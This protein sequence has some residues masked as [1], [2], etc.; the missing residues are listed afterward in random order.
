MN[1]SKGSRAHNIFRKYIEKIPLPSKN[2]I[3]GFPEKLL[4]LI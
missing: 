3:Y 2:Q 1:T 4:P